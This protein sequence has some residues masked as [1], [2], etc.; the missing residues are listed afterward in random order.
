MSAHLHDLVS[1]R[2]FLSVFAG[3][4]LVVSMLLVGCVR[5]TPSQAENSGK[6]VVKVRVVSAVEKEVVRQ[7][8]QPATV[9]AFY[10]TEIRSKVGGYV[11]EVGADIGE[12]V[13]AGQV[14]AR[15]E[16]PEMEKRREVL[17]ARIE[18]LKSQEM[19]AKA[20]VDLAASNVQ[21]EQAKLQRAK[22]EVA[23]KEAILSAA[24]AEFD[25]TQDLVNRGSLQ[26]RLLDESQKRLDS[27]KAGKAAH[28]SAVESAEAQVAVARAQAAA[29][30]AKV[31][32]AQA[33]TQVTVRE[34]EELDV[35]LAYAQV[36]APFEGVI[37]R[38][39]LDLGDLIDGDLQSGSAPLFV[40][41]MVHKV[42]IH[43]PV[44]EADAPFVQPG[45]SLTLTFPS[46]ASES[47]MTAAVTRIGGSLDPNTRTITAEAVIDNSTGK[48]MPG[49]F[50]DA[51]VDMETQVATTML[52]SRAVR[53]DEEG[54][55]FVYVITEDS[56]V[57]IKQ[58][59]TG[60]DTGTDLEILSGLTS[61]QRVIGAHLSRFTDGQQVEP[62]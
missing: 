8:R 23:E 55:A 52:P 18:L 39:Y 28:V 33:Q 34:L 6:K 3:S 59:T 56:T 53:F 45:D 41:S 2:A 60:M 20:G 5:S 11:A 13:Q 26:R 50:G 19:E 21:A 10:E 9:K 1:N 32:A 4:A 44:P 36:R 31:E 43:V 22:S 37:T 27:A 42:R 49:M 57:Q 48:L 17:S 47:A 16:I 62:L 30:K 14:L 38:R 7:T 25:R 35:I 61:G 15:I 40:L 51:V 46:F 29:A 58:V 24:N 12:V 54:N